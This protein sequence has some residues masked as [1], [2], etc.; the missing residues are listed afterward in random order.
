MTS[1]LQLRPKIIDQ[2]ISASK[3]I[4]DNSFSLIT[5]LNLAHRETESNSLEL[6]QALL[7]VRSLP[8]ARL[9]KIPY[10]FTLG[11]TLELAA[12]PE[13]DRLQDPAKIAFELCRRDYDL[14]FPATDKKEFIERLVHETACDR[15]VFRNFLG[16]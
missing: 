8:P 15:L 11:T 13:E 1:D 10:L 12:L 5:L 9:A 6:A 16:K 4:P 14:I 2:L 3:Q 7:E